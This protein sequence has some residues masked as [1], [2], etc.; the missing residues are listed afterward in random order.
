MSP[1]SARVLA[2]AAPTP[3]T[4]EAT[5]TVAT[6]CAQPGRGARPGPG[7]RYD[8]CGHPRGGLGD[9]PVAQRGPEGVVGGVL[10]RRQRAGQ[11][12]QVG[13]PRGRGGRAGPAAVEQR[14]QVVRLPP[15]GRR[16]MVIGRP[17][18]GRR[19][20]MP[21]L[22]TTAPSRRLRRGGVIARRLRQQ[23]GQGPHGAQLQLLDR[24]LG[25]GP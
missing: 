3:A 14:L 2:A 5:A 17:P 4:T 10:D 21:H 11:R 22:T 20:T 13:Q 18:S 9:Q 12:H 7:S 19:P 1:G 25:A 15:A 23:L 8:G 16:Q 24:A 6:A